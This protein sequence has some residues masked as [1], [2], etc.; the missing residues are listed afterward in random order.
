MPKSPS[1]KEPIISVLILNR[2]GFDY[3]RRCLQS[4][5]KTKRQNFE[6]ILVDNGSEGDDFARLKREFGHWS[7]LIL[8]RSRSNFG[9]TGGNNLASRRARGKFLFILNNDTEVQPTWNVP[10]VKAFD[11]IP[12]L[13]AVQPQQLLLSNRKK[14]D[15][16]GGYIDFWGWSKKL[17]FQLPASRFKHP[18]K[19]FYA[20]GSALFIPRMLFER[21]GR[22]QEEYFIYYEEVDLCWKVWL[23]GYEV[24]LEP[25]SVIYHAGSAYQKQ[26]P[27]PRTIYLLRRNQLMTLF[28]NYEPL[29]ARRRLLVAISFYVASAGYFAI[30]GDL[31]RSW[32][33]L[34]AIGWFVAHLG[35]ARRKRQ[36][37]SSIRRKTD[38]DLAPLF[39]K[40]KLFLKESIRTR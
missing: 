6:V 5:K 39:I 40:D 17:G 32:A 3:T 1:T 13:G 19:I 34:K 10:L 26:Q 36:L 2:N 31:A 37:V 14:I 20:M 30:A 16:A 7:R 4:L 25:E 21:L 18:K 22:F 23:A 12:R 8:I 15:C 9:F 24:W 11:K 29:N 33:Y 38:S 35:L 28:A 27:F